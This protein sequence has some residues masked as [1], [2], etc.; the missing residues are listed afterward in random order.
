MTGTTAAG[1]PAHRFRVRQVLTGALLLVVL[2]F[3]ALV[4]Y[5]V[6]TGGTWFVV[7]TPS[8]G[9][10]A[11]V[12][13]LVWVKPV[14]PHDL[15]VG[16]LITFHPP[17]SKETYTHRIHAMHADGTITTKGQITSPDP[18]R[19]TPRN[20]VGAVQM[21]WWGIGWLVRA[22]PLLILGGLAVWF[23]ATRL[24]TVRWRQPVAVLGASLVLS[25]GVIIYR[26]LT[27]A[28]AL[29]LAPHAGGAR[30]SYVSTGLLSLRLSAPSGA[31]A[32]MRP[33]QIG[34]VVST[35]VRSDGKFPVTLQ[36]HIPLW[37]WVAIV[38]ACLL[39]AL[40]TT[41]RGPLGTAPGPALQPAG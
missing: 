27:G 4:G 2:G 21:R 26:P 24:A 40:W 22:A 33:G 3:T 7:R 35:H 10:A 1:T 32:D 31:H 15:H 29:S 6:A 37:F 9:T 8:M 5:W 23:L 38:L 18:W 30:A 25:A 19:I 11:P 20:I 16:E 34:T 39:P 41:V 17:G 36:P 14:S 12:G 13:T 28:V